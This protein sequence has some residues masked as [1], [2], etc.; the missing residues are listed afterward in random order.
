MVTYIGVGEFK[1][2]EKL[3]QEKYREKRGIGPAR[4]SATETAEIDET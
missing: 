3:R 2:R 4:S 1:F